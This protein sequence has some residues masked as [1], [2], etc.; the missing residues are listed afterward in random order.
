MRLYS[1][2]VTMS[3]IIRL[4]LSG[5]QSA[6]ALIPCPN[7]P[8]AP[9]LFASHWLPGHSLTLFLILIYDKN[10]CAH[11]CPAP[12]HLQ[13]IPR[14]SRR[15]SYRAYW[16]QRRIWMPQPRKYN[17]VSRMQLS[18]LARFACEILA[19]IPPELSL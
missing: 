6:L 19:A 5:F 8:Y 16:G 13:L 14:A 4:H 11:S 10:P 7:L 15:A 18:T 9:V 2:F 17:A 12:L 1:L 3:K